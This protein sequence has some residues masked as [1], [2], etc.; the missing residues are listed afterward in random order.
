MHQLRLTLQP[1]CRK[2]A[3]PGVRRC[4]AHAPPRDSRPARARPVSPRSLFC[5][6]VPAAT[7]FWRHERTDYANGFEW[8]S[9]DAHCR[10]MNI[11]SSDRCGDHAVDFFA[12]NTSS[13][14][15]SV[16]GQAQKLQFSQRAGADASGHTLLKT[17]TGDCSSLC[18]AQAACAFYTTPYDNVQGPCSL[19]SWKNSSDTE[20]WVVA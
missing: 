12:K 13:S 19:Y 18:T 10:T 8:R 5:P 4:Q 1:P 15:F 2:I 9:H 20:V 14:V 16:S 3:T 17:T 11:F 6:V 7:Q